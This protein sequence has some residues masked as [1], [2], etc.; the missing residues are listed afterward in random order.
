MAW[1]LI[2]PWIHVGGRQAVFFD[3]ANRKIDF[4]GLTLWINELSI[5]LF[6]ILFIISFIL[7]VTVI[8][9]RVFC[10]WACPI[11]VFMEFAFRPIER[12][13]EGSGVEQKLFKAKPLSQRLGPTILKWTL[14][15]LIALILG[16]TFVAYL[17]GSHRMLPMILE[18][19]ALHEGPFIFMMISAFVILFQ[20][21]WFREQICLF[22]CPYGRLQSVLLDRDSK[23]VAYDVKRGEPRG[24]LGSTTGDCIDCKLC[25][26]VCPTGIDIRDGLQLECVH[27]TA[28]IDACDSI[29]HKVNRAEGLIR[30][31]TE[32]EVHG[33]KKRI[34]RPRL[35]IYAFALS[36]TFIFL[37]DALFFR[38]D[39]RITFH[40]ESA[41]DLYVTTGDVIVNPFRAQLINLTQKEIQIRFVSEEPANFSI[42]VM[43]GPAVVGA[44]EKRAFHLL[45][46]FP[47]EV[48][49]NKFGLLPIR[50]K[51][52]DQNNGEQIFEMKVV[53]P[54][55]GDD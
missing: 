18:G 47:K 21:G 54:V 37:G 11:T 50:F 45:L 17:M 41:R 20:Y 3:L 42:E 26:R 4:L 13:L 29:M 51:A 31:Q 22:V 19:P 24:K 33:G 36:S 6:F 55:F 5:I 25:V 10:G 34:L 28:C 38:N 23:I 40:R 44:F 16:N 39:F 2:A 46:K 35:G 52:L 12:W 43:D 49:K 14:F 8:A 27:C 7:L 32:Q 48:F 30:Y 15:M 53:G 9:G 1:L